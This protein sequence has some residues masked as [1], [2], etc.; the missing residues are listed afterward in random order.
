MRKKRIAFAIAL[1]VMGSAA[2]GMF[3]WRQRHL[4]NLTPPAGNVRIYSMRG[5]RLASFFDGLPAN[6]HF[7]NGHNS[8][9]SAIQ[10]SALGVWIRGLLG[11]AV[12][13]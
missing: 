11:T 1:A 7:S 5:E 9:T 12:H 10:R 4:H 13:A 2:L 8:F 6:A 3:A